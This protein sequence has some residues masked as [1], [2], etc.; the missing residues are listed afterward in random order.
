MAATAFEALA[1]AC[2]NCDTVAARVDVAALLALKKADI[3]WRRDM[4]TLVNVL[5]SATLDIAISLWVQLVALCS[6][7]RSLMNV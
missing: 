1:V 7:I 5:V 2:P 6:C 3:A 4:V